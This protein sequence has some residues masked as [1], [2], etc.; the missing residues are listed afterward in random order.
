ME[1]EMKKYRDIFID[2]DDTL[3]DTRGNSSIALREVFTL[4][5]L[6]PHFPDP[7]TFFDSFWKTNTELWAQYSQGEI[8]RDYLMLQRFMRPL[9]KGL[10]MDVSEDFCH[11]M[12]KKFLE[13]CSEKSGVVEGA[14]ELM[15]HLKAKGYRLH[16]CSN[17]F[18]EVQYKK[19]NACGLH[20]YFD[21]I[22]LSEQV[23]AL[24]PAKAFY[25][26]ALRVAG[27]NIESTIMIGDNYQNDVVGAMNA[28]IDAM[29]FN[30]WEKGFVPPQPVTYVVDE[31]KEIMQIL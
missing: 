21:T 25:D 17:G 24:K 15:E 11:D 2:F 18:R 7:E 13:L 8:T 5:C 28:G 23:G 26:A 27:A 16:I 14:H 20:S 3:Y 19:L 22:I 4:F 6:M 29:L 1:K 12:S 10:G 9:N 31:L 30:R